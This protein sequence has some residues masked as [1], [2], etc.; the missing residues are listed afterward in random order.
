MTPPLDHPVLYNPFR[1]TSS[2]Q[3]APLVLPNRADPG[4]TEQ[5][6]SAQVSVP[7]LHIATP[8]KGVVTNDGEGEATKLGLGYEKGGAEK[9]SV[10][11]KGGAQTV[12][13]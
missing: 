9:V 11:L 6:G 8:G 4:S 10:M 2:A 7:L 3:F 1:I 12:F 13:G 5:T